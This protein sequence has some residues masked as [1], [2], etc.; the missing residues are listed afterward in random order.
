MTTN[1][2]RRLHDE[3]QIGGVLSLQHNDCLDYWGIDYKTLYSTG[4]LLGL[5]MQR[6]PIRDFNVPDIRARLPEAIRILASMQSKGLRVYVHCTAGLGRAPVVVLGYLI[7]VQGC[8]PEE[9]IGLILQGRPG[10]VPAWEAYYGCREDL[11]SAHRHAIEQRAYELYEAK[12][13]ANAQSDWIQAQ[14]EI[15]RLLLTKS[16]N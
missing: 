4:V 8:S 9:A 1:D 13:N 16:V 7:M 14:S 15:L 12:V 6:C 2:L 3:T 10:A 11:T 5:T